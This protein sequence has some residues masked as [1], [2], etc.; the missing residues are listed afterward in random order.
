[1]LMNENR[2]RIPQVD[3]APSSGDAGTRGDAAMVV[4][5][6]N[7]NLY[8]CTTTGETITPATLTVPGAGSPADANGGVVYT[9]VAND[10]TGNDITITHTTA[11]SPNALSVS[12]VGTDITVYLETAGSPAAAVSTAAAVAA[13][14]ANSAEAAALVTATATGTGLGTAAEAAQ[15][16]LSG[17]GQTDSVW[18]SVALS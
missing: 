2:L 6:G 4:T 3:S 16:N 5:E 1:M 10:A 17:G 9:A 18:S 8:V 13:A 12:V 7:L 14:I 11:G 15:T